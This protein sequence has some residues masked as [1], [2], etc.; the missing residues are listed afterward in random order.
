MREFAEKYS[1]DKIGQQAVDQIPWPHH[2]N[3]V[4]RAGSRATKFLCESNS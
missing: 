4:L 2:T 3:Y 1:Y